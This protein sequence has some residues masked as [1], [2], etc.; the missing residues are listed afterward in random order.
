MGIFAGLIGI[1][2][3]SSRLVYAFGRDGLLPKFL[4]QVNQHHLPNNALN[5][6]TV[7]AVIVAAF[8]PF[9]FLANLVSAGTL[10]AFIMVSLGI[11]ALRR[12]EGK[13]LPEPSFKMPLYPVLPIISAAFS[14]MIFM[15]LNI[16]AKLLMVGWFLIGTLIY[17]SYGIRHSKIHSK[18]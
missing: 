3:A 14:T 11:Y 12:R 7:A 2:L 9:T 13:D 6:V 17:F 15:G 4:G 1:H 5:L 16:D 10:I 18:R 8:L